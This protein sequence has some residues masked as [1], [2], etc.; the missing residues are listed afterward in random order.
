MSMATAS[1]SGSANAINE[2]E[3]KPHPSDG[4]SAVRFSPDSNDNLLVSSWDKKLRLYDVKTNVLKS[5]LDDEAALLDCCFSG[6]NPAVAFAGGLSNKVCSFNL[7]TGKKTELGSHSG[8]VKSVVFCREK[9]L[10]VS[11]SWDKTVKVWDER[12][13]DA[14]VAT[15][16]QPDKVY[17]MD[18]AGTKV[19][20]GTAGRHVWMWD[21]RNIGFVHQRR[22]SSLKFQTRSISCHPSG[23]WFVLSSIEGRVAV[24]YV[25]PSPEAQKKKYAFKCHRSTQKAVDMVYP[26]NCVAFHPVHG[27]FATGGCDGIVNV[28]DG[29]NKKR[30]CQ[31]HK[32]PTSIAGMC[33]SPE[34]DTL[35]IASSYTYEEGQKDHPPDTI[36]IRQVTDEECR[37]KTQR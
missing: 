35:A 1:I 21:L 10:L 27:T 7:E 6:T 20:V 15:L 28:W 26:V 24:E 25:D 12:A 5:V 30:I 8:S 36:F 31:F 14:C 17:A 34:G 29:Y 22:E 16:D 2:Y 23:D 37:P 18:L 9:G 19:V 32:Y 4:V 13:K 3:L 33:F 11:G